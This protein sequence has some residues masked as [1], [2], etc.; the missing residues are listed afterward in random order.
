MEFPTSS[1]FNSEVSFLDKDDINGPGLERYKK[2]TGDKSVDFAFFK[3]SQFSQSTELTDR[4]KFVKE[5]DE[6]LA[7]LGL[8]NL[9]SFSSFLSKLVPPT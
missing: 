1:G 3:I 4:I 7:Q 8:H 2:R 9:S 6:L 5:L